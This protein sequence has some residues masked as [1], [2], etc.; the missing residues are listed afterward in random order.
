MHTTYYPHVCTHVEVKRRS[1]NDSTEKVELVD[2][3]IC[4]ELL[5]LLVFRKSRFDVQ[6]A[7]SSPYKDYTMLLQV[8][9]F[10]PW[11]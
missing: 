9:V 10:Q 5:T 11:F 6:Y 8:S 2:S 7:S 4:C 3:D 1:G